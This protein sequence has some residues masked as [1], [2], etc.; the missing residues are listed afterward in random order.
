MCHTFQAALCLSACFNKLL[1]SL[2]LV[3]MCHT[4]TGIQCAAEHTLYADRWIPMVQT[5]DKWVKAALGVFPN[6]SM[7]WRLT[8]HPDSPPYLTVWLGFGPSSALVSTMNCWFKGQ[9]WN[10]KLSHVVYLFFTYLLLCVL[11]P[12]WT[13]RV[14]L[15]PLMLST[16]L[17]SWWP[18]CDLQD[19]LEWGW[20]TVSLEN[21]LYHYS[22]STHQMGISP[23]VSSSSR[24]SSLC[25][26]HQEPVPTA[27]ARLTP[28]SRLHP[29]TTPGLCQDATM[30]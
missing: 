21:L 3:G 23:L 24:C 11:F 20:I 13:T 4:R 19:I 1:L 22:S 15:T 9:M 7:N 2:K 25:S 18:L 10:C 16:F 27:M 5:V 12:L 17:N 29:Y 8:W 6:R 14:N 28:W 30:W 26:G